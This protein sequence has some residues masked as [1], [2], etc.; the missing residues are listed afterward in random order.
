MASGRVGGTRSRV[1]GQ[2]GTEVYQIRKNPDGSYSQVVMAK[3]ETRKDHLTYEVARQRLFMSVIMRHMNLLTNFMSAFDEYTP[4]GTLSVQEFVRINLERLKSISLVELPFNDVVWWPLYGEEVAKPASLILSNGDY[5]QAIVTGSSTESSSSWSRA[6]VAF[7]EVIK[8]MTWREYFD[9]WHYDHRLF[10]VIV[11][12]CCPS[13]SFNSRYAYQRF[14]LKDNINLDDVITKEAFTQAWNQVGNLEFTNWRF[15]P[16]TELSFRPMCDT[17]KT[18]FLL[19]FKADSNFVCGK[20]D[21]K[22]IRSQAIMKVYSG[23]DEG[24][25]HR[26]SFEDAMHS[27]YDDRLR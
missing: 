9:Y 2:I 24:G 10:S 18:P 11:Y 6:T 25:L 21:G 22:K 26:Y 17:E 7:R 14:G 23:Y 3:A 4:D 12:F 5:T 8:G 1:S 16:D 20:V 15:F 27:W 13:G 19:G